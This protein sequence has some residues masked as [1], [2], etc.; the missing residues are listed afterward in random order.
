VKL[1]NAFGVKKL[2]KSANAFG[3]IQPGQSMKTVH[4]TIY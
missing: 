2:V 1:A 4:E 3:V